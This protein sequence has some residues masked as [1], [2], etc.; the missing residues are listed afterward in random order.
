MKPCARAL[1]CLCFCLSAVPALAAGA[2]KADFYV[3]TN[4]RD[5][6]SGTLP[7]PNAAGT[8]GPFATI[9]R[10]RDAV[11]AAR[12]KADGKKSSRVL[13]RGGTYTLSAPI[14]FSPEDSGTQD[15]PVL[16][17]AQP[18]EKPVFSGGRVIGGWKKGS[19]GT[20]VAQVPE[21]AAGK[22]YFYQLFVNGERRTRARTPNDGY[23]RTDGPLP[24]IKNPHAE[25]KNR[26]AKMGMRYVAGDLK[27]WDG[28]E[29]VNLFVYQSWTAPL[30]WIKS[31]DET[32]HTV[33]FTAPAAWPIGYWERKQ[34]YHVENYREALD[35]PGE[36]YLER[37]TGKLSYRPLPGEDMTKA[38]VVA[39]VLR[40][41]VRFDGN[42]AA[43]KFVDHI[44]LRGLAFHHAN[45]FVKN[46]G[47]ADGQAASWLEAA[48]YARGARH[49]VVENC[50]VA[51]VGEYGLWWARGCKDNRLVHSEVHDLGA[52]GVRIGETASPKGEAQAALRNTIDNCFIHD[53]G[54]VFRAGVGMWIGRSSY[55]TV[56]HNEICDF[57]YSGISVGWS[58]GYAPSSANHNVF[59]FNHVHHIG[60]GVLS[61]MGGIY[62]LGD[63]PGTRIRNN[64][65]H[66]IHSYA[67]G[68]WGL[69]TDEGSTGVLMENNVVYNTKTGGFH[70]HYGKENMVRNNILAF[71]KHGQIIRSREEKHI[72]FTFERNIVLCD[73]DQ[74]FGSNWGNG[75]YKIDHNLYWDTS[76]PDPDFA[77]MSFT[78]W[79]AKGRDQNSILAAPMFVDAKRGDFNLKSG[80]PASK[81]GFKPIDVSKVGLYGDPE[82]VEA[83]KRIVRK[84]LKLAEEAPGPKALEDAFEDTSVGDPA[85][86]AFTS[87]EEKGASIRVTDEAAAG[88][89]RSLKFT[90][91]P[92]LSHVWQPHMFYRPRVDSGRVKF[93]FAV[94]V[95]KGAMVHHEWRDARNPYSVGPSIQIMGDG[96]LH[97]SGKPRMRLPHGKWVR[98][99]ITCG[100]G[101]DGTGKYDLAVTVP[102]KRPRKFAKL[103]C[104]SA[105]FR[106]LRWL[107]WISLAPKKAV[108][109]IDD[110]KLEPV[111]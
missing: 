24:E 12:A 110:I 52:G 6:W 45:W 76:T 26:K 105:K 95:E 63:S 109:Y 41:L 77:S 4:G 103:A 27:S 67:Y 83:P 75:N 101:K 94:R 99:E 107:G 33:H 46:K 51:H 111:K 10:A 56:T 48:V 1:I 87:G 50:E 16:Y 62:S 96:Q 57:D 8:N 34:R 102:G 15:G 35:A 20:W 106:K 93:T 64:V 60:R 18:G 39:P 42:P 14:V 54:Y 53:G 79:Q 7:A 55:N 25:R 104:G 70:Q 22:W 21:V 44:H 28:L 73:N 71:S 2:A 32:N 47:F 30:L 108:F 13:I 97:A 43:G 81:I 9:T 100:L 31:V 29:D 3:A 89:K 23:L 68:G 92:G 49:C 85:A 11:R 82:W 80:S 5:N 66:D 98:V 59:E 40:K 37:K 91:A 88:G 65:F 69:Y 78:D 86:K 36:W 61:D 74:I 19:D 90:D 38:V 72:S 58:W 17:A 84:P